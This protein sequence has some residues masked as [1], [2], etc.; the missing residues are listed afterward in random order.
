MI[1]R[2]RALTSVLA[3]FTISLAATACSGGGDLANAPTE[4]KTFE[5]TG[6]NLT[7]ES[8]AAE[9][10]IVSADVQGIEVE[11]QISG[12]VNGNAPAPAWSLAGNT[13]TLKADCTGV[14][15]GCKVLYSVK[16]PRST[17]IKA[18]NTNGLIDASDISTGLTATTGK[19]DIKLNNVT[20]PK[21]DLTSDN[22]QI[23]GEGISTKDVAATSDNGDI[24]LGFGTVPG[25][26]GVKSDDGNV[27]LTLPEAEYR[28]E[29]TTKSGKVSVDIAESD[30][31]TNTVQVT[32]RNGDISLK[33][34]R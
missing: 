12:S 31:S 3:A 14:S 22:G 29:T 16:V 28:V 27:A 21:V 10:A 2:R 17:V 8:N 20:G 19:G 23:A 4:S 1:F 15:I 6:T 5:F 11:R 7:V 18:E 13:L 32:T 30:A 24:T 25:N 9:L 26:V 34:G 33:N